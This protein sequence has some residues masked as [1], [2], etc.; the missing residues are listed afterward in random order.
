MNH[1]YFDDKFKVE[2]E[3]DFQERT[4]KDTEHMQKISKQIHLTQDGRTE[5]P[6]YEFLKNDQA[7]EPA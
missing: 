4:L 6:P 1:K 2:F 3:R 5:I 7:D